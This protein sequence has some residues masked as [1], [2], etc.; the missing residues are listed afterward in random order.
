[1]DV[2]TDSLIFEALRETGVVYAGLSEERPQMTYLCP[3]GEFIVTFDPLDGS[4]II[5]TNGAVGSIFA[6]WKRIPGKEDFDGRTGREIIGA[7]LSTYG[8]RTCVLVY[9]VKK[10]QIDELTLQKSNQDYIWIE[11]RSQLRIRP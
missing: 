7:A 4:S 2:Q 5:E 3:D 9:N 6:I 10:N 11:T 8:S 1:M